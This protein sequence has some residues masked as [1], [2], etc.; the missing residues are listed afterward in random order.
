MNNQCEHLL[1]DSWC[2]SEQWLAYIG[3]PLSLVCLSA[4]IMDSLNDEAD[5][6]SRSC[7]MQLQRLLSHVLAGGVSPFTPRRRLQNCHRIRVLIWIGAY[8]GIGVPENI[9]LGL[10]KY[11]PKLS[12]SILIKSEFFTR[13]IITVGRNLILHLPGNVR[14]VWKINTL[15]GGCP[16]PLA[17]AYGPCEQWLSSRFT[18]CPFPINLFYFNLFSIS[19]VTERYWK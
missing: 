13:C 1:R 18:F 2:L 15:A 19:L 7:A 4:T 3:V 10:P 16:G 5:R 17:R 9:N 11:C 12:S 6:M 8:T 14:K